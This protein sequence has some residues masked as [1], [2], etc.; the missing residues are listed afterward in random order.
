LYLGRNAYI[1]GNI[2]KVNKITSAF[3]S[4]TWIGSLK[5]A[6]INCNING[7]GAWINGKTKNGRIAIATYPADNDKIYIGYAAQSKI[8]AGT[9][10]SYTTNMTW[11]GA[12]GKLYTTGNTEAKGFVK[13]NSSDSY[14]LLGG[15]GQKAVSDFALAS[16]LNNYVTLTSA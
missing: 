4:G 8:D 12:T 2:G 6:V 11:D 15:G 14:L 13:H 1:D 16:S 3:S 5:N 9:D 7:F 10:N